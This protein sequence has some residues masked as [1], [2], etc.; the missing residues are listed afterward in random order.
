MKAIDANKLILSLNDWAL[1]ES[2]DLSPI[3]GKNAVYQTLQE[4]I[5][6]VE[7]AP[8]IENCE[9]PRA[10]KLHR[11]NPY[12]FQV[13]ECS[14]YMKRIK[15]G[16]YILHSEQD[17]DDNY[18]YVDENAEERE[19]EVEPEQW[20]GGSDFIKTYYEAVEKKFTGIVIGM[21]IIT[22]TAELFCDSTCRPDGVEVDFV[23]RNV[24]EQKKVA[25]VAY[26]CNRARLVP[27]EDLAAMYE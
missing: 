1:Q 11:C 6:M 21:K 3:G 10:D 20:G 25:V 7:E 27:L 4:V 22:I 13:V 14:R 8:K 18:Y 2:Y 12:M 23:N 9:V 17:F 19:R 5:K 15:D 16:K 26:G 24:I